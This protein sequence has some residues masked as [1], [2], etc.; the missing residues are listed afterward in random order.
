MNKTTVWAEYLSPNSLWVRALGGFPRV[1]RLNFPYR[2]YFSVFRETLLIALL[3]VLASRMWVVEEHLVLIIVLALLVSPRLGLSLRTVVRDFRLPSALLLAFFGWMF[4]S[5]FWS[6]GPAQTFMYAL[7][8]FL[9]FL[10]GLCSSASGRFVAAPA[11]FVL[12]G[13]FIVGHI[14]YVSLSNPSKGIGLEGEW[15]GLFTNASDV[16]HLTGLSLVSA[17][18]LI[19][20]S[21][22]H[23]WI[24]PL[25][26]SAIF[27]LVWELS[28]L[29]YLTTSVAIGAA[30][31]VAVTLTYLSKWSGR[32]LVRRIWVSAAFTA[33]ALAFAWVFRVEIQVRLGKSPD[34]SGR[35]PV[36]QHYIDSVA[37]RPIFGSGW[38][39]TYHWGSSVDSTAQQHMEFFP[40]H[41]GFL[42]IAVAL[43]LVGAL[44]IALALLG[45]LAK[46]LIVVG[47][48]Y[49]QWAGV[50]V[51]TVLTF[52]VVHDL[53]GTWIPRTIG[54]FVI[55]VAL[56]ALSASARGKSGNLS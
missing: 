26:V 52:L 21:R 50:W 15:L 56:G 3:F 27:L 41:N 45:L 22:R 34:F 29:S 17:L 44:T 40:A 43:G 55:G 16:A 4:L 51:S 12:G 13:V 32:R 14:I 33:I 5:L 49:P 11:G 42:D 47:R 8:S 20:Q 39:R 18:I 23:Q 2:N 31:Y 48:G 53:S 54:L 6:P 25:L 1:V 46:S 7:Y 19:S 28:T 35:L 9:F 38:G 37:L 30:L 24:I 36:W 10:V